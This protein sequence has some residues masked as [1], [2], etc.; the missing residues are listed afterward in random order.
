MQ[1]IREWVILVSGFLQDHGEPNGMVGLWRKIHALQAGPDSAVML[2]PWWFDYRTT[3]EFMWRLRNGG[4]SR[5]T[6]IGYSW[7]GVGCVRLAQELRKR[8][9]AVNHMILS[10]AVYRHG[11]WLGNWRAF[12]PW[13]P[14]KIPANVHLVDW[15]RQREAQPYGH[16]VVAQ[17]RL[18]TLVNPPTDL[19]VTHQYMDDAKEFHEFA[20]QAVGSYS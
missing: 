15:F 19:E 8:G 13:I 2:Y 10:D 9:I 20:V 11:Y 4:P 5:V 3:A 18:Y 7:G 1:P 17:S 16:D 12:V 6:L 14:I